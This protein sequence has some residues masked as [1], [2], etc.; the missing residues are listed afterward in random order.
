MSDAVKKIVPTAMLVVALGIV[1]VM[2]VAVLM[3]F[4]K[5][6][7]V[8]T[9]ADATGLTVP[10]V[11]STVAVGSTGTYPFLQTAT[12]CINASNAANSY[13]T[14]MYNVGEGT[15][16][17]GYLY[18]LDA[19]SGWVGQTINCSITYLADSDPQDSADAFV[20]GLA[21]FGT[22][23]GV[24]ILAVIGMIIMGLFKGRKREL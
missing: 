3:G 8:N 4:S 11:N 12:T 5:G 13:A 15:A 6:L 19:G 21:I 16:S 10:A 2:L 18:N 23:I 24:I 9:S 14:S 22:F 20:T 7:R 17:G 1:I